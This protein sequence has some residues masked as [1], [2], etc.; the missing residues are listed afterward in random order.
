MTFLDDGSAARRR[1]GNRRAMRTIRRV[2]LLYTNRVEVEISSGDLQKP[3]AR[4]AEFAES[5]ENAETL[6]LEPPP[7]TIRPGYFT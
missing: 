2:S 3:A 6:K 4:C 7:E 5:G 1:A